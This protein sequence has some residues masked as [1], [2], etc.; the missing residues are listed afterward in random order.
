M[1]TK[2]ASESGRVTTSVAIQVPDWA[3]LTEYKVGDMVLVSGALN[4]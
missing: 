4:L 1:E 2:G 3:T